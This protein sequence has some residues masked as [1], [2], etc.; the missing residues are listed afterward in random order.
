VRR[1]LTSLVLGQQLLDARPR[2]RGQVVHL[3]GVRVEEVV[4]HAEEVPGVEATQ[5]V[6]EDM[7]RHG[8]VRRVHE[9]VAQEEGR[10]RALVGGIA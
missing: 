10:V 3:G 9:H 6:R 2:H 4:G 5:V 1:L 8:R 7:V